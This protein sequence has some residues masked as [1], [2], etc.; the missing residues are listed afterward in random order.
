[1]KKPIHTLL[2]AL[3]LSGALLASGASLVACGGPEIRPAEPDDRPAMR[4]RYKEEHR[5]LDRVMRDE[6]DEREQP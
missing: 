4:E 1:M 3:L 5:D 6:R 2:A